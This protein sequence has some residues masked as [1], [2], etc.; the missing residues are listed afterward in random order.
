[1]SPSREDAERL[2]D[3]L[4]RGWDDRLTEG[5]NQEIEAFI[6]KHGS[7]GGELLLKVCSVHLELALQI[8]SSQV[9]ERTMA[10]ISESLPPSKSDRKMSVLRSWPARLPKVDVRQMVPWAIAASLLVVMTVQHTWQSSS[11]R[12]VQVAP[13]PVTRLLRPS[14]PVANLVNVENAIWSDGVELAVGKT[15]VEN[16]RLELLAGSAQISMA[17]GADFVMQAPCTVTLTS[18]DYATLEKG[19]LTAQA[20][21]WATGFVVEANDLLVTDLGTRFAVSADGDGI[22]E[23]HVLEGEVLA[24]P[25]R[26]R[27]PKRSSMLLRTGQAIRVDGNRLSFDLIDAQRTKFIDDFSKFRPLRPIAIWNTGVGLD[28]GA[29]DLHWQVTSGTA[30]FGPY[31]R[32]AIINDG[33]TGSYKDNKPE[34][35]QW[36][37]VSA[38][39]YPGVKPESTHTFETTFDLTGYDLDTVYL[40]GNFLV[41]DAINE[42]RI[43]G[44]PVKFER[45]ETTWDVWDF[46]SFHPIEIVDGFVDGKNVISIDVYNSPSRPE[47]PDSPNPTGLRVE[48]QAYGCEAR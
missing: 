15:L 48:W 41:D 25:M 35:S 26:E 46:Q 10:R 17:S 3:L 27:R 32:P 43:N 23:A 5:D 4:S 24:E 21:E 40:V 20:A 19:K 38:K 1:M 12:V 7:A 47:T 13:V 9:F 2:I 31:P 36:I 37:S 16:Q 39:A 45:W 30:E 34:V 18:D 8:R 42:L 29:E 22:V 6:K 11:P 14:Q 33:D 28:V 44:K